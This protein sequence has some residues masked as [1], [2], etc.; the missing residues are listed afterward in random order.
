[1]RIDMSDQELPKV[2]FIPYYHAEPLEAKSKDLKISVQRDQGYLFDI[3]EDIEKKTTTVIFPHFVK[4]IGLS[5][6]SRDKDG[7]EIEID[8]MPYLK[9]VDG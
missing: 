2:P 5:S 7:A 9:E 4:I 3:C 8:L 1:M 6:V